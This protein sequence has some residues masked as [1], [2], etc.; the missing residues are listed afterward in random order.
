MRAH[1]LG[2]GVAALFPLAVVACGLDDS[3]DFQGGSN[4]NG[5]DGGNGSD[6]TLLADGS[7]GDASTTTDGSTTGP[8]ATPPV[9][10]VYATTE[11]ELY[12]FDVISS[13]LT[14][15][16]ALTNCGS[17]TNFADLAIDHAGSMYVLKQSD[18]IYTVDRSGNCTVRSVLSTD[19]GSIDKIAGRNNGTPG[20]VALNGTNNDYYGIDPSS[21]HTTKIN[22][23]LFTDTA[24]ETGLYDL[25]CASGGTCWTALAVGCTAG[26]LTSSC[27]YTFPDDGGTVARGLGAIGVQ[28][29]GLAYA[30]GLLYSFGIDGKIASIDPTATPVVAQL[31]TTNGAAEPAA[32]LG[33]ASSP[34][35]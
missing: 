28:P 4:A 19:N 30:N 22:A 6:A 34:N 29:A 5:G 24:G 31:V 26:A 25:A 1:G 3:I 14:D 18:A 32:W 2:L 33:A 12:S 16:G 8:D 15:I 11:T 10:L 23:D 20:I 17:S 7:P 35:D 21:G 13:K 9:L 27:L